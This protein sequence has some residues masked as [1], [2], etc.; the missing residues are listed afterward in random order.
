MKIIVA[1][2]GEYFIGLTLEEYND[3]IMIKGKYE[4]LKQWKMKDITWEPHIYPWTAPTLTKTTDPL[5]EP[6]YKI[7]CTN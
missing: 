7:T 5:P 6:P 2:D 3:F 4:E 1:P